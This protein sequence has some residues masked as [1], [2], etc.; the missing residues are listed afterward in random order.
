MDLI[1][2][3]LDQAP[4]V[5][6]TTILNVEP[7]QV[8]TSGLA[9]YPNNETETGNDTKSGDSDVYT[10]F[11]V[12]TSP[13]YAEQTV[14]ISSPQLESRCGGGWLW[15][16]GAGVPVTRHRERPSPAA[17]STTMATPPSSSRGPLVRQGHPR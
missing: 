3:D 14:E 1:E 7:P 13:V 6:A 10:V 12:D 4:Y 15:E 11:Y 5:T 16:P 9:A 17:S 8:T 2:A